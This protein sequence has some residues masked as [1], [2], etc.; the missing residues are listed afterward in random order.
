MWGRCARKRVRWDWGLEEE[1]KEEGRWLEEAVCGSCS[2]PASVKSNCIMKPQLFVSC[3]DPNDPLQLQG[4]CVQPKI[5]EQMLINLTFDMFSYSSMN[6]AKIQNVAHI[7]AISVIKKQSPCCLVQPS[8]NPHSSLSPVYFT[9]TGKLRP[10]ILFVHSAAKIQL[11]KSAEVESNSTLLLNVCNKYL[12]F[13][14]SVS[15]IIKT[16]S[17]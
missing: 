10:F 6:G 7:K 11:A 12:I 8:I 5:A 16:H 13:S 15:L 9:F 4:A 17:F 1:E 2:P 14:N 3:F